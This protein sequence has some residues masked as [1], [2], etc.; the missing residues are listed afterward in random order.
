MFVKLYIGK[1]QFTEAT[2]QLQASECCLAH[3]GV[4]SSEAAPTEGLRTRT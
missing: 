1:H 2:T 3:L 4:L